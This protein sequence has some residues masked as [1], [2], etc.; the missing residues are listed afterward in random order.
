MSGG[1]SD[2]DGKPGSGTE[3]GFDAITENPQFAG[4]DSSYFIR[5]GIPFI[6]GGGVQLVGP[7]SELPALRSSKDEGQS[8][9]INP[10]LTLLG[11]GTDLDLLPELR[12]T[13]NF[14]HLWFNNPEVLEILRQQ[15]TVHKDIGWDLSSALT[16]RPFDTQ[17][18]VLRLSGALLLP[19][20]GFKDLY[21]SEP[22][23]E[24][25][26]SVLTNIILKY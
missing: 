26:Y 9:F 3:G 8:N 11:V 10:G 2:G 17:N 16:Y 12:L 1:R 18:V 20:Q 24:V 23:N 13:F 6:G 7:N 15:P 5:E 19:G 4:A 14:N 25:Y 21:T 22:N